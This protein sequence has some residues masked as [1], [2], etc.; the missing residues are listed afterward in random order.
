VSKKL[1]SRLL[2]CLG[3]PQDQ[4]FVET[5]LTIR[6]GSQDKPVYLDY[7]LAPN[8][9]AADKPGNAYAIIEVKRS[10][11]KRDALRAAQQQ[12]RTYADYLRVPFY[13]VA[14]GSHIRIWERCL[15]ED[16][17]PILELEYRNLVK[18]R[19]KIESLLSFSS[20]PGIVTQLRADRKLSVAEVLQQPRGRRGDVFLRV[21]NGQLFATSEDREGQPTDAAFWWGPIDNPAGKRRRIAVDWDR[22]LET[23]P[24]FVD[25][26][27][28]LLLHDGVGALHVS[29]PD[30]WRRALQNRPLFIESQKAVTDGLPGTIQPQRGEVR[31]PGN[32]P[33]GGSSLEAWTHT[34][35]ASLDE[36]V[37][38][39][40]KADLGALFQQGEISGLELSTWTKPQ[41]LLDRLRQQC[42]SEQL[43]VGLLRAVVHAQTGD[44]AKRHAPL[45]RVRLGPASRRALI[46]GLLFGL[47]LSATFDSMELFAD[48]S[49]ADLNLRYHQ[50]GRG[51]VFGL[52][53]LRA[54]G[55]L[56]ITNEWE[57]S[58]RSANLL[59][60]TR[61]SRDR[62]ELARARTIGS[63]PLYP[64]GT[65]PRVG[66]EPQLGIVFTFDDDTR[67]KAANSWEALRDALVQQYEGQISSRGVTP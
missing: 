56:P 63:P 37:V 18:Q 9:K 48:T 44:N 61:L 12:A 26:I 58:F 53:G 21:C 16:D 32:T 24:D 28:R 42:N 65:A 66:N 10:L 29:D 40:A 7:V 5:A 17:T 51:L 33:S 6:F 35:S 14:D 67:N 23:C 19:E 46:E 52:D 36:W 20:L 27:C 41:G 54:H 1:V 38:K 8:R 11:R 15:Y 59:A 50:D 2:K 13:V 64:R 25:L 4:W 55:D 49:A 62:L 60:L 31:D 45:A 34:L 57:R 47:A 39:R 43:N 22:A 3:W 30:A